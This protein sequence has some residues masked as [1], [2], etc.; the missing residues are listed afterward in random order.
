MFATRPQSNRLARGAATTRCRCR[1]RG[2]LLGRFVLAVVLILCGLL[3]PAAVDVAADE[4][5]TREAIARELAL[6]RNCPNP[7]NAHTEI[8]YTLLRPA[9]VKVDVYDLLG[10]HVA[11]LLDE[12][13]PAGENFAI[14]K[15][16]RDPSGTYIFCV[17]VEGIRVFR[18]MSMI[19]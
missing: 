13:Q 12:S 6:A 11:E 1:R 7:F 18:K 4:E 5:A 14:W 19:K 2:R 3:P 8:I 15:T 17:E 10:R 9:Q 16:E